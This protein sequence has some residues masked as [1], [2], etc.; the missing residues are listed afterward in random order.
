MLTVTS[1]SWSVNA[2]ELSVKTKSVNPPSPS[3]MVTSSMAIVVASSLVIVPT[4]MSSEIVTLDASAEPPKRALV[5]RTANVSFVSTTVS[6]TTAT[7]TVVV[8][9]P[10]LITA[11]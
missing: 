7:F 9:E 1:I 5:N 6:P 2:V 8:S 3:V 4:P 10:A 11:V